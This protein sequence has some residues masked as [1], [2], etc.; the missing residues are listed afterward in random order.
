[1]AQIT[2]EDVGKVYPGGVTAVSNLQLEVADG[3]LVVILGPS[4]CGKST[5]LRM[6]AGLEEVTSGSISIGGKVVDGVPSKDR[7]V[8]MVFQDHTLY[9]HM[10]ARENMAFALKLRKVPKNQIR[11]RVQEAAHILGLEELLDRRPRA[12]SGGQRQ[13]VAVGRAIV[14]KPAVFLLDEPLSNL[15]AGLR[16]RMR[17]EIKRL[18]ARL[19]ATMLYVTHDQVEAMTLGQ[20]IVV[21][22]RGVMQQVADPLTLYD[23]PANKF[24]AAFVGWPPMNFFEGRLRQHE[25]QPVFSADSGFVVPAPKGT[26]TVLS[27]YVDRPVTLG[28]RPE[29]VGST[30]AEHVAGAPRITASVEVVEPA[31][32]ESHVH[33][34]TGDD[35]FVIRV[36]SH[37][38]FR[39]GERVSPAVLTE[40]MHFFDPMTETA[41]RKA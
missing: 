7:N 19:G 1:M 13:R 30:V 12:L 38:T 29:H 31:G 4:G 15:D 6:V 11:T 22:R 25:G 27:D 33:L 34:R 21:M 14:R 17:M 20:R 39:V 2:L 26:H 5:T 8:V 24:V 28:I 9:P 37:A 35:C 23:S 32:C 3:E 40:K 18:H 36:D 10:T 41:L 16:A